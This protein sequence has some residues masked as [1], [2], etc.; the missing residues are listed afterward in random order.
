M[1]FALTIRFWAKSMIKYLSKRTN[2][3]KNIANVGAS[4]LGSSLTDGSQ[5]EERK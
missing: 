3:V 2:S 4:R 1:W 5:A